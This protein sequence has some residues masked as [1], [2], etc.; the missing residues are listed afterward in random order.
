MRPDYPLKTARLTLRPFEARDLDDVFGYRS[1]PDVNTYLYSE[2]FTRE[3]AEEVLEQ[4]AQQHELTS[5]P[6]VRCATNGRGA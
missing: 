1:L 3:R 6:R 4:W 5:S 2:P